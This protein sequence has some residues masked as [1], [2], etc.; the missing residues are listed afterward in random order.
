MQYISLMYMWILISVRE[1]VT[2]AYPDRLDWNM[3]TYAP[4][5]L[6]RD[7]QEIGYL[8][9][10]TYCNAKSMEGISIICY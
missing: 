1:Y 9:C 7:R 6:K 8:L 5:T 4:P 3:A 10:Y 2:A